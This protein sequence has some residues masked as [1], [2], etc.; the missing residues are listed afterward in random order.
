MLSRKIFVEEQQIQPVQSIIFKIDHRIDLD[1][2]KPTQDEKTLEEI[3]CTTPSQSP[4]S[5]VSHNNEDYSIGRRVMVNTGHQVVNK[6]GTIRF[7]GELTGKDG[8]WYGIELEEKNI[9]KNNGSLNGHA[10]F[11]CPDKQGVFV[12]REKI[13]LID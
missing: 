12:R 6:I 13:C 3:Y 9:G 2:D 8:I 10:Y 7:S 1:D 11:Q 5:I 4:K